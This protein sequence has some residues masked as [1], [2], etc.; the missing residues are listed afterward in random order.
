MVG[1]RTDN[2]DRGGFIK[3]WRRLLRSPIWRNPALRTFWIWCLLKASHN[4]YE[5]AT[6][7]GV[8]ELEPGQFY[9]SLRQAAKETRLSTRTTRTCLKELAT[10]Q[11][12]THQTTHRGTLITIVNWKRYQDRQDESGAPSDTVATQ[13]RHSSDTRP[14]RFKKFKEGGEGA[15]PE[16]G[17]LIKPF[18]DDVVEPNPPGVDEA[19]AKIRA[20]ISPMVG[21]WPLSW[22]TQAKKLLIES[23]TP[24]DQFL[25]ITQK[26]VQAARQANRQGKLFLDDILL[27]R[28]HQTKAGRPGRRE[29][30][31]QPRDAKPLEAAKAAVQEQW[32]E[33]KPVQLQIAATTIVERGRS[34]QEAI[35]AT[36]EA[37]ESR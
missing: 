33:A 31:V 18:L 6:G 17:G 23:E 30:E 26:D 1:P 3:L 11:K 36:K 20:H 29:A 4:H 5:H 9:T 22:T 28:A 12:L 35:A 14:R 8:V 24:L 7:F 2:P 16:L 25:A 27:Q 34:V 13:Q 19:I 10:R 21:L 37:T 15:P 32:P